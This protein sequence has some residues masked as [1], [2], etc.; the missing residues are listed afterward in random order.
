MLS[1]K[2]TALRLMAV[3]AM[4]IGVLMA[5]PSVQATQTTQT[6]ATQASADTSQRVAAYAE[7]LS[8]ANPANGYRVTAHIAYDLR[9]ARPTDWDVL[10]ENVAVVTQPNFNMDRWWLDIEIRPNQWFAV[11]H[12]GGDGNPQNT[13]ATDWVIGPRATAITDDSDGPAWRMSAWGVGR[14]SSTYFCNN[15][16]S[17]F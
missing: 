17:V 8:C 9:F 6:Q 10:I 14:G 7:T 1:S 12:Y 2:A 5:A 11:A 13:V 4:V 3:M 16:G 15:Y